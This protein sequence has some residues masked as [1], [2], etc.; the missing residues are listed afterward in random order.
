MNDVI[1]QLGCLLRCSL[2]QK[3]VFDPL[4]EFVNADIDPAETS[5]RRLERSNHIQSPACKGPRRRDHLQDLSQDMDL[6]GKELVVL[7]SA[8]KGFSI[9][10]GGR[11]IEASSESLSNLCSRGCVVAAGTG[12]DLIEYLLAFFHGDT[13]M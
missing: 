9:G 4:G 8:N 2:D 6:F 1:K 12:M 7:T 13:L 10:Y 11:P 5:W 3:F